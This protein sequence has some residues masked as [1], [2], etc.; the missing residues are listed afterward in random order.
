MKTLEIP[1]I[2]LNDGTTI[3]QLA[4]KV[5][6]ELSGRGFAVVGQPAD[7]ATSNYVHTVIE[8]GSKAEQAAVNTL[9]QQI[10][11]ATVKLASSV[12][13]GTLQLILGSRFRALAAPTKPLGT[14]SGSFNASSHCR[15]SSFF[16]ANLAKPAGKVRC[17]C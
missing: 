14:I 3:P 1:R 11:G 8:Y 15:N 4:A 10:P 17:A 12:T 16:G 5:S 6:A 7:A 13:A 9:K 2:A